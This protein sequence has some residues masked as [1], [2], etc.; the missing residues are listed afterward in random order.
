MLDSLTNPAA[1][2]ISGSDQSRSSTAR[3]KTSD[4]RDGHN[5]AAKSPHANGHDASIHALNQASAV[6]RANGK[7]EHGVY[8]FLGVPHGLT[9]V[10]KRTLD[11]VIAIPT[12]IF[13]APLMLA[14]A[15]AIRLQDGGPALFRQRRI[16]RGG[17]EFTCYK[18]RSM[19]V[20]AP[21]RLEALLARD[22]EARE[23]WARDQKLRNDPRITKLGAFLRKTSLD[24]VPQLFNIIRGEMSIVGPRPIVHAEIVRYEELFLYYCAAKPGV[25]GLWQ[26]SGRN[27]VTYR[28]RVLMDAEYA[29]SWNLWKDIKIILATLPAVLFSRGAY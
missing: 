1:P 16:G 23:E 21:A 5:S 25:T 20:D 12:L 3:R 14:L 18:F 19:L 2:T 7:S 24:E 6:V 28:E 29:K 8:S 4:L 13:V 15:I 11:L 10:A 17:K 27:D 9:G 26:V 22:P